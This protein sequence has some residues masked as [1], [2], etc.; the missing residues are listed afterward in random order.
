MRASREV[1]GVRGWARLGEDVPNGLCPAVVRE[2]RRVPSVRIAGDLLQFQGDHQVQLVE[3]ELGPAAA[4]AQVD[5]QQGGD[6]VAHHVRVATPGHDHR[7]V[8]EAVPVVDPGRRW[9]LV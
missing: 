7:G 2:R 8:G 1:P 5:V 3:G 4:A 6:E 9:H